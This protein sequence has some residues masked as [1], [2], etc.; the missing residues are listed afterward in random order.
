MRPTRKV[1]GFTLVELLVVIAIIGILIALLLPAVQ[2]AREAARRSQCVSNL[3]QLGLAA[4][5][6]H[7]VFNRLPSGGWGYAWIGD[8]NLGSDWKQPGGWIFNSLPY[9]E[10]STVHDLQLGVSGTPKLNAARQMI[11][12]PLGVFNCPTRRSSI[13]LP[14]QTIT[15]TGRTPKYAAES[16]LG[17][18]SDYAG[19][20]GTIY[21]D[22][23]WIDTGYSHGLWDGGGPNDY[24]QGTSPEARTAWNKFGELVNGVIYPT[25]DVAFRHITDGSSNTYLLGEKYLNSDHYRDAADGGDNENMYIGDNGDINRW[26]GPIGVNNPPY[27]YQPYQDR[28]GLST[29]K[30]FGS[31]HAAGFNVALCDGSVRLISYSVDQQAHGRL[32]NRKDGLPVDAEQL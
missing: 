28:P 7:S 22:C 20:G 8:P 23:S 11:R 16:D 5:N 9:V 26:T 13:L 29:W 24:P 18:R 17:A 6:H 15:A 1:Q 2:A 31:A 30:I 10:Q 32:G 4:Q 19:N 21:S 12:T 14:L 3:K 25:S 27:I